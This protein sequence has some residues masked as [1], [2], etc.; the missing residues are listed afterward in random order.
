MTFSWYL[1]TSL[2]SSTSDT[3][4]LLS[5]PTEYLHFSQTL[6]RETHN[7]LCVCCFR[8]I[9]SYLSLFYFTRTAC[10]FLSQL[11]LLHTCYWDPSTILCISPC[12]WFFLPSNV[13]L[14]SSTYLHQGSRS[15]SQR[16]VEWSSSL[17]PSS[18]VSIPIFCP[19]LA[20][21]VSH[22]QSHKFI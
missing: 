5:H 19:S 14:A 7:T 16:W 22:Q 3:A 10:I 20:S 21:L 8:V 9:V 4:S 15:F 6:S 2:M 18:Y 12:M 11:L 1:L 13:V 17:L